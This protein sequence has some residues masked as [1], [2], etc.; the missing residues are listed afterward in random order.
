MIQRTEENELSVHDKLDTVL[1]FAISQTT[2]ELNVRFLLV[3]QR[4]MKNVR[5]VDK[6][7][8]YRRETALQGAL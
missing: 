2:D 8:S 3:W 5:I 6:M 7:L 4:T 1:W